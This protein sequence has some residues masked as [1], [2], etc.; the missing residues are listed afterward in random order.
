MTLT[1]CGRIMIRFACQPQYLIKVHCT[2]HYH[3]LPSHELLRLQYETIMI[4]DKILTPL[5][6]QCKSC[7]YLSQ[8]HYTF[9]QLHMCTMKC[10]PHLVVFLLCCN[11]FIHT[12]YTIT[13]TITTKV[14]ILHNHLC[15]YINHVSKQLHFCIME[16][17]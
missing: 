1:F 15:H 17:M 7:H 5:S 6:F 16:F 2:F 11:L 10:L 13:N 14:V 3:V 9:L 8:L 4:V 12:T